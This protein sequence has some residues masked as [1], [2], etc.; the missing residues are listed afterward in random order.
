M[1]TIIKVTSLEKAKEFAK[2]NGFYSIRNYGKWKGQ[3]LYSFLRKK[4]DM[5]KYLGHPSLIAIPKVGEAYLIGSDDFLD[6][7][8]ETKFDDNSER[9]VVASEEKIEG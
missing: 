9:Y 2:R 5:G 8:K 7:A 4:D 3:A 6:V 1:E